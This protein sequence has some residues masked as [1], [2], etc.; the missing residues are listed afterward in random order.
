MM[1]AY[2]GAAAI[3]VAVAW[4][5]CAPVQRVIE[6]ILMWIVPRTTSSNR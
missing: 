3:L 6:R 2:V 4:L 5:V 1:L